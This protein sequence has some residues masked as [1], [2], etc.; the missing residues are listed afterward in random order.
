MKL[1]E[2]QITGIRAGLADIAQGCITINKTLAMAG[3][4]ESAKRPT[5]LH[6]AHVQAWERHNANMEQ[7]EA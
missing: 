3:I 1:T 6:D 4:P 5:E 7:L 2:N